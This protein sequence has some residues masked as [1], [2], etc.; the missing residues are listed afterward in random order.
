MSRTKIPVPTARNGFFRRFMV[1]LLSTVKN[2]VSKQMPNSIYGKLKHVQVNRSY[3]LA[4]GE[5]SS[6][7]PLTC[8]RSVEE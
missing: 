5:G 6:C 7:H 4:P 1:G 8:R 2:F 3:I